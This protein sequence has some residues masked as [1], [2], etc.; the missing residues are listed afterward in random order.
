[1]RLDRYE[2]AIEDFSAIIEIDP[3]NAGAYLARDFG[4]LVQL[5]P[6]DSMVY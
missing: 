1:M 2:R 3:D 6:D 5:T 4:R